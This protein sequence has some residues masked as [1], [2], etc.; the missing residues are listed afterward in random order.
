MDCFNHPE[1]PAVAFCRSC[2]KALCADCKRTSLGTIFCDDHLPAAPQPSAALQRP[3]PS[4]ATGVD[5]SPAIAF[6]LGLFIPGVGA[7]YNA[8]YA[9]GL[10]H[11]LIFGMLISILHSGAA[12]GL[13][14]LLGIMLAVFIF[15]MALEAYHTARKRKLGEPVDEFSSLVD[16]RTHSGSFPAGAITLIVLGVVLLLNTLEIIWLRDVMRFWPVLLIVLGV[17]M[18]RAR[19]ANDSSAGAREVRNGGQ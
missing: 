5:T 12:H 3:A 11:A 15:Y 16:L 13:E 4:L 19:M 1:V 7:I 10:V 6:L 8:Q 17:Y 2:G 14:P 18:L 9:K